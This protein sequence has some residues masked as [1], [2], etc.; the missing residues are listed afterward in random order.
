[1]SIIQKAQDWFGVSRKGLVVI[2]TAIM[3]VALIGATTFGIAQMGYQS[4]ERLLGSLTVAYAVLPLLIAVLPDSLG[5]AIWLSC[6]W[7][8]VL[9]MAYARDIAPIATLSPP[10][11][12]SL[13]GCGVAP[14]DGAF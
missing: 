6:L 14:R 11:F 3:V 5:R 13:L 12:Y 2:I 9:A 1:M 7:V 10:A 8:M 4:R